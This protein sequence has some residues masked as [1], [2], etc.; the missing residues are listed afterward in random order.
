[1]P[2]PKKTKDSAEKIVADLAKV[3]DVLMLGNE[4]QG[5]VVPYKLIRRARALRASRKGGK[6]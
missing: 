2:K 1:M 6:P 3:D 4:I 5:S